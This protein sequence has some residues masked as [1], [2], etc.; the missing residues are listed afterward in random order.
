[1]KRFIFIVVIFLITQICYSQIGSY[2][3]SFSRIGFGAR[4]LSMGNALTGDIFGDV[5][6]YYNPALSSFQQEGIVG[7]GYTFMSLD[8]KLNFVSF[9]KRF[10]FQSLKSGA[11][12]LTV[13]WVN[14]Q[15]TDIDARDN[16]T[17]QTGYISTYENQFLLGL[18][19]QVEHNIAL[20][21]GVKLY[22]S[23]LYEDIKS[24]TVGFDIG[25]VY[26]ATDNLSIG[27][28]IRD[29]GS[30]Y[31]WETS[32]IYSS[33]GNTTE[34]KFP[35]LFDLGASYLL[36]KNYGIVS[37]GFESII[38]PKLED[39]ESGKKS[40]RTTKYHIKIGGEIN[41]T[42]NIKLR[43]GLDRIGL[44]PEDFGAELRPSL[45]IGIHRNFAENINL[46]LDY[47]FQLEP[48]TKDPFQ[49]ISLIFKFK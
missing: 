22:Y 45:G 11:A 47:V 33:Y 43:A 13:A 41:I 30:K 9:N 17:K 24:T 2:A 46:G 37:L 7:I 48:Y 6:G 44:N 10:E 3:G 19:F 28:A 29:I 20:G 5:S 35:V 4:G 15:V 26:K 34:D 8:R 12:G 32:K 42:E 38:S 25:A 31:R 16:D 14:A 23:K 1:L 40:N 36:P 18:S 27:L 49:N 21:V 39:R